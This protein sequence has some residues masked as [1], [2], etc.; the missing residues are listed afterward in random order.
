MER[1]VGAALWRH[2]K[3]IA[4]PRVGGEGFAVPL[5]DGVRRIGQHHIKAPEVVAFD[6]LGL[7]QGVAA[8]DAE[9]LDAV[10]EAVHPGNG[11]GHE[12]ALLTVQL[13][14]A[15]LLTRSA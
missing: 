5:L 11:G 7:G 15:P 2:T 4:P 1:V 14:I 8:L 6:Q 13:H 3:D 9:V 10:Q 12:I